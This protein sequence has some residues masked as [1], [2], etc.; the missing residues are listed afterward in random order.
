DYLA[1]QAALS[2]TSFKPD[3]YIF[4][5]PN[6]TEGRIYISALA[7]AIRENDESVTIKLQADMQTDGEGFS[8][9]QYNIGSNDSSRQQGAQARPRYVRSSITIANK[10]QVL[11]STSP[12]SPRTT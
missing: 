7:D 2:T 12:A 5:P 4:L 11:I 3:N 8:Y 10:R 1:P 6:A 9:Q